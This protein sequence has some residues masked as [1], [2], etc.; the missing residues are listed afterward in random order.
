MPATARAQRIMQDELDFLLDAHSRVLAEQEG[1]N[2]Q[3]AFQTIRDL[4]HR[5]RHRYSSA[6]EKKLTGR[7]RAMSIAE[8]L[9]MSRAFALIFWLLNIVEERHAE[10][11]RSHQERAVLRSL[12]ERLHRAG[13]DADTIAQAV[14]DLR[15][16]IVLTAHPTEAQRWSIRE[17]LAR[18]DSL[19]EQRDHPSVHQVREAEAEILS[20]IT[21]LWL[22]TP[23]RTQKPTPL[24]EVQYAIH[25][26]QEVLVHAIPKTTDRLLASFRE[27][28]SD[29][30]AID[31]AILERAAHRSLR[32]G[33]WMG[34]DRDGNPFVTA[35]TTRNALHAYRIAIFEHYSGQIQPLLER[36]TISEERAPITNALARSIDRDLE[37]LE[38]LRT[39]FAGH[40][41]SER[42]RLK[43]NAIAIR[44]EA[45]RQEESEGRSSGSLRGYTDATAMAEDLQLI[46]DSLRTHRAERL[47][48]GPLEDL[49][50]DLDVFGFDFVALDIRQNQSK[51]RQARSELIRPREGPL[52]DRP[53][54]EQRAF[55]E[56]II[57]SEQAIPIP[58]NGL[59][60]ESREVIDTL[61][62]VADLPSPP[63]GRSIRDLVISDTENAVPVLELLALCRQVG[64]LRPKGD[65]FESDV[66]I[67]P[68]FESIE[69]LR[70]AAAS[71]QRLYSSPTYRKQLEARG[72]RQQIMLGYS[73]SMKDGGY[74]AACAALEEVQGQ[75][76]T[77]A[78]D[79]GVRL[80]FF[81]GRG[82]TIARGGGPT[83]RAILAQPPGTVTGRI[84][85]TEQG[86]VIAS[87][88]G[89]E[90]SAA[91]HL[92]LIL[93]AT[94]EASLAE[95][96][97]SGSRPPPKAWRKSFRELAEGSREA[98][99]GLVYE[100]PEFVDVFYAMTPVQ[101]I[102]K[103][104][105]GSRPAKRSDTRA[106]S[107]LRAIPWTFSWNQA[108]ILL[109][110]WYG[111]GSG[112]SKFCENHPGGRDKAISR[113]KTMYRR[114][115]YFRSVIDN[116][117][118]V[119]AKTDL[120]IGARYATL[121]RET[122]GAS[123]VFV[124]IESEFQ[125]TLRAVRDISGEPVLLSRDPALREAL[126]RRTPYLD[127]LS[128]L[129]VELLERQKD[130]THSKS[131]RSQLDRAIHLT[132]NGIAAGLRNTG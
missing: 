29:T 101:E 49:L 30:P 32:V 105:L 113:L 16:T 99:R 19:L 2:T 27:V 107:K 112:F 71:M 65:R 109:P 127:T 95:L 12:F 33:S 48:R 83:H 124:R 60:E 59:S 111:A 93:A 108:R 8:L 45:N 58:E 67:V 96:R 73:D 15:A 22:S 88:Y 90:S 69:S 78:H 52:D 56:D 123:E 42:Y 102:S 128:Y 131:E 81:H 79:L 38:G 66:N 1:A 64:L 28:Y 85:L 37:E 74:L 25:I 54:S 116:L 84:K 24:D 86:E 87:K 82:G 75:L 76:A 51:H 89:S 35:E 106:I 6:D 97:P 126:D 130:P 121:A 13:V 18:I 47:V 114:W 39:R 110:S 129:Q 55:L 23:V 62:L 98:Y 4:T 34:G 61:Q 122:P 50:E 5:L 36:L 26:L 119:L 77:Q 104:N 7:L 120:H 11:I 68:L 20:E 63:E 44:L 80:E 53:L 91:Y 115:P 46:V 43:L 40:N 21:G 72:M 70:G 31:A 118:Q 41:D 125:R 92:E 94:L 132:I 103:L 3:G 9:E 14:T 17:T 57:S 10:R 117:E 100:M